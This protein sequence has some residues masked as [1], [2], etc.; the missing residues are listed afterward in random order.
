M[1]EPE[2]IQTRIEASCFYN[3]KSPHKLAD[4]LGITHAQLEDFCEAGSKN[5]KQF[6]AS[7]R[8]IET[9]KLPLKRVQRRIHQLLTRIPPPE[10]L[11]SAYPKRSSVA[12]ADCHHPNAPMVKMDIRRF[13]PS[14]NGGLVF[15]L[16]IGTF[17]CAPHVAA[18][19]RKL[20]TISGTPNSLRCHLP[21]G[22]VTSPI[23]S[24]FCYRKM[25]AA[26]NELAAS[27][28]LQFS[29]FADDIT[30][31]GKNADHVILS[32]ARAI[33]AEHG[34][35]SKSKK[36]KVWSSKHG[37]KL[38]TGV[39]VTPKGLRVPFPRKQS[40]AELNEALRRAVDPLDRAKLYQRL[41]GSLASAGQIEPR[42]MVGAR[43]VLDQWKA[44][45]SA[46]NA[47]TRLSRNKK[48][49]IS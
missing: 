18:S 41:H 34:L 13:Y 8:W 35:L 6:E 45:G 46:W 2:L 39:L 48:K 32:R 26:L 16:F 12:N 10:F 47:H 23:L 30:F 9:P 37:N 3:L 31:S 11:F 7:D 1:K 15:D 4:L 40:I 43:C 27:N 42:F 22:G 24:Y 5:Y 14:T 33:L 38:V 20:C 36:E 28:N 25:F 49:R 44:D 19:L 21:T 17:R 29:I